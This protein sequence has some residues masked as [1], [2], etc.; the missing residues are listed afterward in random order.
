MAGILFKWLLVGG[1]LLTPSSGTHHPIYV[2][3]TEI[4]HNA[5]DKTLEISCKIFTDDFEKTLRQQNNNTFVDLIS[6]KDRPAMEKLVA[7]YVTKHLQVKAD[8]KPVALQYIGYEQEEEGIVSFY[9]VNNIASVRKLDITDN[10]LFEYKKEQISIIHAIVNG[11]RKST[12][13]NNPDEK[14]SFEF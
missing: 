1:I 10:I 5:K 4:E 7:A 3:V 2:S 13:L 6:P 14:A 12:K 11:N 8:G 9:Q